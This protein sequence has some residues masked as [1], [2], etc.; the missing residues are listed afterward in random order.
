M[1]FR[2]RIVL[3]AAAAVALAIAGAVS[4]TYI[5]VRHDL[6]ASVDVA[7]R[8]TNPQFT[9]VRTEGELRGATGSSQSAPAPAPGQLSPSAKGD[10]TSLDA[11]VQIPNQAFGAAK[12]VAQATL[13]TGQT[14]RPDTPAL[15]PVTKAVR[16]VA[17][18]RRQAFLRDATVDG[19]HLRVLTRRGPQGEALQIARPLTDAD[20]TLGRLR[21]LLAAV[22]PSPRGWAWPSRAWRHVRWAG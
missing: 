8:D 5:I 12:G 7:L 14:I 1:T 20:A 17:A 18:G 10:A 3:L 13:I 4:I 16:D 19:V 22:S 21:W 6:R 15:L 2:R 9:F 11:R